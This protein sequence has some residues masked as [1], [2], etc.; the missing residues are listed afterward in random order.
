MEVKYI[1]IEQHPAGVTVKVYDAAQYAAE[2]ERQKAAAVRAHR[3]NRWQERFGAALAM[4]GF[5]V[6]L[7]AGGGENA[8]QILG[9]GTVGLVLFAS[10]AWLA[11]AFYGQTDKAGWAHNG[12]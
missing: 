10:G 2:Q 8:A 6:V 4:L 9:L 3:L 1:E 11:H 7:A 12:R 5:L